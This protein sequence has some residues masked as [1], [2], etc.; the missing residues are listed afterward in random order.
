MAGRHRGEYLG[1]PDNGFGNKANSFDF[2]IRA[3]YLRPEFKTAR[4]GSGGCRR[5]ALRTNASGS[6]LPVTVPAPGLGGRRAL[7]NAAPVTFPRVAPA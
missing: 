4:G 5:T 1:M 3:Y 2:L 7:V 6:A